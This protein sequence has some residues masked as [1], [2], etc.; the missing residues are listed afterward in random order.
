MP[1]S[2][3]SPKVMSPALHPS[4]LFCPNHALAALDFI[5]PKHIVFSDV[6]RPVHGFGASQGR[7]HAVAFELFGPQRRPE[8]FQ[9]CILRVQNEQ[10]LCAVPT[11]QPTT[12]QTGHRFARRHSRLD[13]R[14]HVRCRGGVKP[15]RHPRVEPFLDTLQFK[16]SH[17]VRHIGVSRNPIVGLRG[18]VHC[19]H[20]LPIVVF[21]GH[22]KHGHHRLTGCLGQA[23]GD[24]NRRENLVMKK[25][26][27]SGQDQLMP[28][29]HHAAIRV[30]ERPTTLGQGQSRSRVLCVQN[31]H[32]RLLVRGIPS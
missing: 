18:A 1:S 22:P 21:T 26:R 20:L 3:A 19:G 32:D 12:H 24:A 9:L 7:V 8:G 27:A 23:T 31:T 13:I 16:V 5:D 17:R 25:R 10:P 4:I 30:C 2:R 15:I 14:L 11:V 28:H 6:R 29:R